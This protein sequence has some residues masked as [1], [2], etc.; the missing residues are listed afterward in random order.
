M[1]FNITSDKFLLHLAD[2]LNVKLNQILLREQFIGK[3]QNGFYICNL[4]DLGSK[5]TH[6]TSF[7]VQDKHVVYFD[8]FGLSPPKSIVKFCKNKSISYSADQIQHIKSDACGYYVIA[9]IQNFN[10]IPK[11][12]LDSKRK[13]GYHLNKFIQPFDVQNID[14]NE[15]ILENQLKELL[16]KL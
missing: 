13:M 10:K 14:A 12:D 2:L 11:K 8:S 15:K 6:W 4:D 1:I 16:I 3:A 7:Y 5:G 9:F